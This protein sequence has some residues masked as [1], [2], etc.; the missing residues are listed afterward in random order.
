MIENLKKF[1][2]ELFEIGMK[3]EWV[4]QSLMYTARELKKLITNIST[5][6]E[7]TGKKDLGLGLLSNT[8]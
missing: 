8:K 1:N 6:T 3:W 5:V 4:T 2:G 7:K